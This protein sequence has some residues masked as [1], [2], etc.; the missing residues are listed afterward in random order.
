[1][2]IKI[3]HFLFLF[4]TL[5]FLITIFSFVYSA[6]GHI[7]FESKD[8]INKSLITVLKTTQEALNLWAEE[9]LKEVGYAANNDKLRTLTTQ[10]LE[11]NKFNTAKINLKFEE[12][13]Q[14]ITAA[15]KR[16]II[17]EFS[18]AS[19]ESFA[20]ISSQR[21]TLSSMHA[22]HI[23]KESIINKQRKHYLDR[24]F[25]GNS[26]FIPTTSFVQPDITSTKISDIYIHVIF[27]AAPIYNE[28]GKIIAA[29]AF[30]FDPSKNFTR[31]LQ[32]GQIGQSG[33]TYAFDKSGTLLTKSRFEQH[34]QSAGEIGKKDTSMM[35]IK[36]TDP[37]TNVLISPQLATQKNKR[38]L[39][40][41][42]KKAITGDF[43]KQLEPYRD[44]RGVAV[45]GVWLWDKTLDIGIATEIDAEEALLPH[46][47][48]KRIVFIIFCFIILL[49]LCL[50]ALFIWMKEKENKLLN[51]HSQQ[52]E[53]IVKQ[54]TQALEQ[55]NSALQKLSDTDP[56]TK[57][58]NRR[59]YNKTLKTAVKAAVRNKLPLSLL[60]IDI[61]YFKAFNDHYGHA[62]GDK[63]LKDVA[64]LLAKALPR[65]TDFIARFGGEEF[66]VILPNT[67]KE[68]AYH[69]AERLRLSIE[70]A[71]IKHEFSKI[72]NNLTVSIG[73]ADLLKDSLSKND[74]DLIGI[75]LFKNA[76]NALY[77]AKEQGRNQCVYNT[78]N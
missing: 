43:T 63:A 58:A 13:V 16:L 74:M 12:K 8:N 68:G 46:D 56:L 75:H 24:V 60:I 55:A 53:H 5:V 40:L 48:T 20:I 36:I 42:A 72:G 39:T 64:T 71:K 25:A 76:D 66:A 14:D 52:L 50:M 28:Q 2:K 19:Y 77:Q 41:M 7:E 31:I 37:G 45:F 33:E 70:L 61:D 10:L 4:P 54:R 11:F 44:Y 6:I 30:G 18:F 15:L 65:N 78:K 67:E 73:I 34:L 47:K 35:S 22:E 62:I 21:V 26:I 69:V 59:L 17:D 27:I 3:K 57:I 49:S 38:P 29:I 23:G 1:M 32:L 9:E 51:K